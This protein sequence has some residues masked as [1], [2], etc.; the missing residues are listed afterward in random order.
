MVLEDFIGPRHAEKRPWELFFLGLIYASIGI[1]LSLWIFD[2]YAGIVSI[3]LTTMATIPLI[4]HT[5]KFE[6][7]KDTVYDDEK[8]ILKEHSKAILFF[9]FLFLGITVAYVLWYV[10]L[11]SSTVS[12]FFVIQ[13][14]TINTI[15]DKITGNIAQLS[16]FT[17]IF[18]NNI[19]VL[20][21]SVLFS[22][23]YGVGAMFILTWNA[24]VIATAIGEFIR[25]SL[26]YYTR[27]YG[28]P[29][30][31]NYFNAAIVG[32]FK[33]SIHG[34]PEILSYFIGGLAG[35]IMSVAIMKKEFKGENYQKII[36]D[37][38]DLI[39]IAVGILL[40]AALLEV[41]VTPLIF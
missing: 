36:L 32:M 40:I 19:K 13:A 33:F 17:K 15:N 26:G 28:A 16:L 25:T 4:Y 41:Y 31:G 35:G 21:F 7:K 23:F 6:E 29:T 24:S 20:A 10:F 18:L 8:T 3:F 22:L 34:I 30:L 11:P 38:S 37:V 2:S 1:F 12:E 39:L 5:M 9:M 27:I 14:Q